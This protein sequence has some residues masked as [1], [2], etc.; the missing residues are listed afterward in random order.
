MK[1]HAD[2]YI[3]LWS[4][5]NVKLANSVNPGELP[6]FEATSY[7][8]IHIQERLHISVGELNKI[9]DIKQYK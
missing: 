2:H 1:K 9:N 3:V 8:I 6:Y 7:V 5:T 4:L